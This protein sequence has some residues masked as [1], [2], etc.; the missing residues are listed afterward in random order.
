MRRRIGDG[1]DL[2]VIVIDFTKIEFHSKYVQDMIVAIY[3]YD[4]DCPQ[5]VGHDFYHYIAQHAND[6]TFVSTVM[7][8]ILNYIRDEFKPAHVAVFSDGARKHFKQTRALMWW[9]KQAAIYKFEI[10]YNFFASYHG[11]SACDAAASHAKRAYI[12]AELDNDMVVTQAEQLQKIISTIQN[13]SA[14]I[15]Y[16]IK[17]NTADI[18]VHTFKDISKAHKFT[19]NHKTEAVEAY[20]LSKDTSTSTV[21]GVAQFKL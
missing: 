16:D 10:S 3:Y 6:L 11:H 15:L 4:E 1:E 9:Y 12:R 7:K 21:Y 17:D 18:P 2:I 5:R 13:H 20:M 8:D 19:F 14:E